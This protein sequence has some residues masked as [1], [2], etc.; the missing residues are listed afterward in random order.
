MLRYLSV[1]REYRIAFFTRF[2]VK[3]N[4]LLSSPLPHRPPPLAFQMEKGKERQLSQPWESRSEKHREG[5]ETASWLGQGP[6]ADCGRGRQQVRASIDLK[7]PRRG[8]GQ[9]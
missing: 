9:V 5:G 2:Y 7:Q 6:P 1:P 4:S 3:R 8:H